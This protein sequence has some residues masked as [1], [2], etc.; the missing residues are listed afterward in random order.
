MGVRCWKGKKAEVANRQEIREKEMPIKKHSGDK[1]GKR[2]EIE[3]DGKKD[4]CEVN[5][6]D[7]DRWTKK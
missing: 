7:T 4:R 1:G 5:H 2:T 3:D 6:F